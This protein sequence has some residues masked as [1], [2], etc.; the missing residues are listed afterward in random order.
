MKKQPAID[1]NFVEIDP[2]NF[3]DEIDNP[4]FPLQPGTTFIY[5]SQDGSEV[6][7]TT[8]THD[9]KEILGVTCVVVEDTAFVDGQLAEKTLDYYA[10][11]TA[12]NVW[13]FGE[14]SKSFEDG[15]VSKEGS[16]L[17]GKHGATPGII[18]EASPQVGDHY[19]Q[20]NAPGIAED[21]ATVDSL[22]ASVKV[23]FGK[24]QHVLETIETTP[25][26]PEALEHKFYAEGV[27]QVLTVDVNTGERVEL[28]EIISDNT[29]SA[30]M[31]T[32]T[33]NFEALSTGAKAAGLS[34]LADLTQRGDAID[35]HSFGA[36]ISDQE[37]AGGHNPHDNTEGQHTSEASHGLASHL[38]PGSLDFDL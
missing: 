20:E 34:H 27:G 28:V 14:A 9:T 26:E 37:L 13:Y 11:D 19:S 5:E 38:A 12:G 1:A 29:E 23:P 35:L 16:W 8:V 18:M 6:V 25:L 36:S 32:D 2:A 31:D 22:N 4:F 24:F 17:A 15:H 33:F 3:V 30:R 10:Q 21:Q 7:I